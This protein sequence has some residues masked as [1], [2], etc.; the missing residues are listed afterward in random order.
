MV[1]VFCFHDVLLV[2]CRGVVSSGRLPASLSFIVT[3]CRALCA[4]SVRML[5]HTCCSFGLLLPLVGVKFTILTLAFSSPLFS[6]EAFSRLLARPSLLP[7][8]PSLLWSSVV[9]TASFRPLL[10]WSS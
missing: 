9:L 4:G 2:P 3:G 7:L 1:M 5:W 10:F 6:V 8:R